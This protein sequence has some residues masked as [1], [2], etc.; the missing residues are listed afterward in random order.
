MLFLP[1][2]SATV[3]RLG[4]NEAKTLKQIVAACDSDLAQQPLVYKLNNEPANPNEMLIGIPKK[5]PKATETVSAVLKV[6]LKGLVGGAPN[7]PSVAEARMILSDVLESKG[8]SGVSLTAKVEETFAKVTKPEITHWALNPSWQA[9]KT[10][11]GTR[12]TFLSRKKET[13]PLTVN[14]PWLS[15]L[16]NKP[17][18]EPKQLTRKILPLK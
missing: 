7:A 9:L 10:L 2:G 3:C 11:V 4:V 12:V 1:K 5:D 18:T 15:A 8:L 6:Q 13:D 16:K 14:D 17:R